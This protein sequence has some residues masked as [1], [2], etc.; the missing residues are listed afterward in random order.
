MSC[1]LPPTTRK[2]RECGPK[3]SSVFSGKYTHLSKIRACLLGFV[4]AILEK[5]EVMGLV[6]FLVSNGLSSSHNRGISVSQDHVY[7]ELALMRLECNETITKPTLFG[8]ETKPD[9]CFFFKT[10]PSSVIQ[11]MALSKM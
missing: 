2:S 9:S 6:L 11:L 8:T 1:F 3:V 7:L 4:K 5:I 10:R